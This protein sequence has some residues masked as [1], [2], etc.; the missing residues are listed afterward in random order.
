MPS[1]QGSPFIP[2][3][4]VDQPTHPPVTPPEN[5][6]ADHA[7]TQSS[8]AA[9]RQRRELSS[10]A[11]TPRVSS[12]QGSATLPPAS[13]GI[14][15]SESNHLQQQ[16]YVMSENPAGF[17]TAFDLFLAGTNTVLTEAQ[18]QQFKKN[19]AGKDLTIIP[20]T[21]Q[22]TIATTSR[23]KRISEQQSL[24]RQRQYLI[25]QCHVQLM[26]EYGAP[27]GELLSD[28]ASGWSI[29]VH[30]L[31]SWYYTNKAE[32]N[33]IIKV[34]Q[35]DD[36]QCH[37][38]YFT[39]DKVL[40]LAS[41]LVTPPERPGAFPAIRLNK[42]PAGTAAS[43]STLSVSTVSTGLGS[44]LSS[45]PA[46]TKFSGPTVKLPSGRQISFHFE[47]SIPHK[48]NNQIWRLAQQP[49]QPVVA[50]QLTTTGSADVRTAIF[51][52]STQKWKIEGFSEEYA[53]TPVKSAESIKIDDKSYAAT[54]D[55]VSDNY[56]LNDQL[57]V[58]FSEYHQQW[59]LLPQYSYLRVNGGHS[60][61]VYF[62][63]QSRQMKI[64]NLEYYQINALEAPLRPEMTESYIAAQSGRTYIKIDNHYYQ[65]ETG[66]SQTVIID[67]D[68]KH[69]PIPVQREQDGWKLPDIPVYSMSKSMPGLRI[70]NEFLLKG[71]EVTVTAPSLT[72]GRV[73]VE[74]KWYAAGE[75]GYYPLESRNGQWFIKD[76]SI[77]MHYQPETDAWRASKVSFDIF[78]TL[79]DSFK[80]QV[81][82]PLYPINS[83]IGLY[84]SDDNKMWLWCGDQSGKAKYIQ[85]NL[86]T[87]RD[88]E[89]VLPDQ[90]TTDTNLLPLS[91]IFENNTWRRYEGIRGG[92]NQQNEPQAGP[93]RQR[94]P[95]IEMVSKR[96][97]ILSP[98]AK[99]WLENHSIADGENKIEAVEI[100]YLQNQH[101]IGPLDITAE[102]MANYYSVNLFSL[103]QGINHKLAIGV[104]YR[105]KEGIDV[106]TISET[107]RKWL[108]QQPDL[109]MQGG[110]AA[111]ARFYVKHREALNKHGIMFEYLANYYR[112]K[113]TSIFNSIRSFPPDLSTQAKNW[114]N[115][116]T[117]PDDQNKIVTV[118]KIYTENRE[119]CSML[120]ISY[121]NLAIQYNIKFFELEKTIREILGMQKQNEKIK[122]AANIKPDPDA[123]SSQE[124]IWGEYKTFFQKVNNINRPAILLQD[125]VT[126]RSVTK[127]LLGNDVQ[128]VYVDELL[129]EMKIPNSEWETKKKIWKNIAQKIVDSDGESQKAIL[130]KYTEI[131]YDDE[132]QNIGLQI[133]AKEDIPAGTILGGYSGVVHKPDSESYNLAT[134]NNGYRS[135]ATYLFE[136]ESGS[137]NISGYENPNRL[138]LLN[139]ADFSGYAS[140]GKNNVSLFYLKSATGS[141][142]ILP[143]YVTNQTIKAGE[144]LLISYGP[145]YNKNFL[146]FNKQFDMGADIIRR[147]AKK[148]KKY[149]IIENEDKVPIACF[150]P[151]GKEV[152]KNQDIN[153]KMPFRGLKEVPSQQ[154]ATLRFWQNKK[155]VLRYN[156][157]IDNTKIGNR[158]SLDNIFHAL[159]QALY[160]NKKDQIN[161]KTIEFRIHAKVKEEP[162]ETE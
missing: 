38:G 122:I 89:L 159:A 58:Y 119:L 123:P 113:H 8:A 10:S 20:P 27:G 118:A 63:S 82:D 95:S 26:D 92:G 86:K 99:L 140:R 91:Y 42:L 117:V 33:N 49:G 23:S 160:R 128:L 102:V 77:Y 132:E 98:E 154:I 39:A 107:A 135:I 81:S 54:W 134:K 21:T 114:L 22:P 85:V 116:M 30:T 162:A 19:L 57:T 110:P 68:G 75:Q 1:I 2:S 112:F 73:L 18:K 40:E 34:L 76:S 47:A 157:V 105:I 16:I 17:A 150:N 12:R 149:I 147:I 3:T 155:G 106:T 158:N 94:S 41:N 13:A 124:F 60:I 28:A 15:H 139:T 83:Y 136:S 108:D 151:E 88:V 103:N 46:L 59:R 111:A 52:S 96:P 138:A 4:I 74:Q 71:R 121:R 120:G 126:G 104:N 144:E 43:P 78:N 153:D 64:A 125:P 156:A 53:F 133:T 90:D 25:N 55:A 11:N 97:R 152:K 100:L 51:N 101:I 50:Q 145:Y 37:N 93:S 115:T 69:P 141:E 129:Q 127:E 45:V 35:S 130:K 109:D 56:Q 32:I 142:G 36:V 7:A 79:P 143:V 67:P 62:D 72:Q 80:Q 146:D 131:L 24:Q 161:S 65:A 14:G 29:F 84:R 66:L 48:G 44:R 9:S 31:K 148:E 87:S 137:L 5:K 61:P 70:E 6:T